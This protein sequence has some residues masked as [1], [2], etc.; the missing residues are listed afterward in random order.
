MKRI[1]LNR[2]TSRVEDNCSQETTDALNAMSKLVKEHYENISNQLEG[3]ITEGIKRKGFEFET[4]SELSKFVKSRCRMEQYE[5]KKERIYFVDD[6]P[7]L[8]WHYEYEFNYIPIVSDKEITFTSMC[9]SYA[10]L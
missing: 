6:N 4:L 7:F 3:V 10:Y 2:G 1:K 5:S 9:G 8:V